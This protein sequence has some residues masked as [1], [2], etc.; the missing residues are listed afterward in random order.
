LAKVSFTA[1]AV[2]LLDLLG[3]EDSL[4]RSIEGEIPGV[5]LSN[6]GHDFTASGDEAQCELAKAVILQLAE[7]VATGVVPDKR[8]VRESVAILSAGAETPSQILGSGAVLTP[9]KT[10]RAK[11]QGQKR[12]LDAIDKNTITF[13]IGPA[14]TG[15]TYLAVAKAVNAL[16]A[17]Q[18]SRIILTRPAVEAGERLG[19]LPGTLSEKIDPYLRPLFDALQEMLEPEILTK[20][21]DSSVIE[22]A[23]LAYMRGRTL[24]DSFIILDEA[25]NTTGEQMKM[26]LTR[27]G[28]NSKMVITGDT[29]Q[30]DLPGGK[31]GLSIATSIL[32]GVEGLGI[33]RLSSKDVVRHE[34]VTRIVDAYEKAGPK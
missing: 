23:P 30:V 11:T 19:F 14:G 28:F 12:Y 4:L 9:A 5:K 6:R 29:T 22:V 8:T 1:P 21:M 7:L 15:K 34:L 27:L 17:K 25:Q 10:V 32:D 20:L 33:E 31:S 18:I 3:P 16:Y 2:A 13:G 26:F 24:N